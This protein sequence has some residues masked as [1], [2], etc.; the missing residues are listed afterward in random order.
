[1]KTKKYLVISKEITKG[2]YAIIASSRLRRLRI[3]VK[4]TEKDVYQHVYG[5]VIDIDGVLIFVYKLLS[6][7]WE[8][9]HFQTGYGFGPSHFSKTRKETI[10]T[11]FKQVVINRDK[12]DNVTKGV[13]VINYVNQKTEPK[14]GLHTLLKTNV[15]WEF[16]NWGRDYHPFAAKWTCNSCGQSIQFHD[17]A[18]RKHPEYLRCSHCKKTFYG[19]KI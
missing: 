17:L 3:N 18:E 8:Y 12:F 9:S 11:A 2:W 1:M 16:G 10:L 13:P 5:D 15:N 14:N 19:V 6:G 7:N 4:E